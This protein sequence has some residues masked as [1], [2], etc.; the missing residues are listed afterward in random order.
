MVGTMIQ[1]SRVYVAPPDRHMLIEPGYVRLTR[2]PH[3][4]WLRPA[5]DPLFRTAARAYGSRVL[6]IVLSGMLG[7][8]TAGLKSVKSEGGTAIVQ[9][10]KE[11]Q[12]GSMPL[13]A[14]RSVSVDFVLSAAEIGQKLPALVQEPWGDTVPARAKIVA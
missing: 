7:D 10:P 5:I 8:G 6:G 4:K 1:P 14:M 2:G 11:A 13:S 12:F 3:E 9:D